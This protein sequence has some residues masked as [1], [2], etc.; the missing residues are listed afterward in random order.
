MARAEVPSLK[1]T[2]H[3]PYLAALDEFPKTQSQDE[4]SFVL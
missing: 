2:L 1:E 4:I 3:Y